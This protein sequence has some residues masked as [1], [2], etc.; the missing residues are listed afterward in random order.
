MEGCKMTN[1]QTTTEKAEPIFLSKRSLKIIRTCLV[2]RK[3]ELKMRKGFETD[4]RIVEIESVL[5]KLP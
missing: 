2:L 1:S 3:E 5:E 4:K